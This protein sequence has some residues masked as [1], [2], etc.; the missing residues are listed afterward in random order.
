MSQ[1]KTGLLHQLRQNHRW[2]DI[3]AAACLFLRNFVGHFLNAAHLISTQL[4]QILLF[5]M[6][7]SQILRRRL[8][9]FYL[10]SLLDF[11][12]VRLLSLHS[13]TEQAI[14]NGKPEVSIQ[15]LRFPLQAVHDFK[16]G[17][18]F[19][20]G[21]AKVDADTDTVIDLLE[22][23]YQDLFIGMIRLYSQYMCSN[24]RAVGIPSGLYILIFSC[25]CKY[26]A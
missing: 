20:K 11:L 23:L 14:K 6:C 13:F 25:P 12:L 26:C 22:T 1:K 7:R 4:W 15:R 10:V 21:H 18:L 9:I 19:C 2:C 3:G 5:V 17:G 8:L 24:P 16:Y